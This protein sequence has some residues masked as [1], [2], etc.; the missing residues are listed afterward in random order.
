MNQIDLERDL[1]LYNKKVNPDVLEQMTLGYVSKQ[2]NSLSQILT[3][4]Q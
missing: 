4:W 3:F 2:D 1:W